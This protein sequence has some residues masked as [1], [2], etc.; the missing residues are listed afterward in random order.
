MSDDSHGWITTGTVATRLGDFAFRNSYPDPV[1][2]EKL[3]DALLFT[4]A[5]ETYL[6][7]MPVVSQYCGWRGAAA[8]EQGAPNQVLIWETLLDAT[9]LVLTGNTETVY[10]FAASDLK[11]DG[12]VVVDAPAG[13]LG[14]M[15]DLLQRTIIDVGVTGADK[16]AGGRFLLLPPDHQGPAPDGY[17][18]SVAD[19]WRGRHSARLSAG[20]PSRLRRRC[21]ETPAGVPAV[22]G[23]L[24]TGS[25][26]RQRVTPRDRL[27]IPGHG[28]VFR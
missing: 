9:S 7:Q 14:F 4:R 5:V 18:R 15:G 19:L 3:R 2:A 13:M 1:G 17:C 6:V 27:H 22:T 25:S 24:A 12:P 10:G 11:R 21:H 28:T 26:V 23:G 8:A 16:G 20:R